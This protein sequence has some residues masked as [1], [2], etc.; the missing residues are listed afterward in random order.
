MPLKN[1]ETLLHVYV[2]HF[3][4][5]LYISPEI[6]SSSSLPLFEFYNYLFPIKLY[7]I[8]KHTCYKNV[9]AET[10]LSNLSKYQVAHFN[11]FTKYAPFDNLLRLI[12]SSKIEQRSMS[13]T[14]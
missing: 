5:T 12:S 7:K 1:V 11:K 2:L 4:F 10:L 13:N 9:S 14:D 8:S 6:L 3:P